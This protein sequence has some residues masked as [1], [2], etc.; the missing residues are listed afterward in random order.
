MDGTI[1]KAFLSL[2]VIVIALVAILMMLKRYSKKNNLTKNN[3]HNIQILSKTSLSSKSHIILVKADNKT[4]LLGVSDNGI[5]LISDL[6]KNSIPN[7]KSL[8][9]NYKSI[10]GQNNS[11]LSTNK[12]KQAELLKRQVKSQLNNQ[13]HNELTEEDFNKSLSFS[14]FL[15]S[16]FSKETN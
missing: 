7:T 13:K 9:D 14:T 10:Y 3:N 15:K 16:A 5:N 4:L 12:Q 11:A 6:T 8:S 1:L 2:S